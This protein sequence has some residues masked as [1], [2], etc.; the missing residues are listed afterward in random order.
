MTVDTAHTAPHKKN[1]REPYYPLGGNTQEHN[2]K[3][4]KIL[5]GLPMSLGQAQHEQISHQW[6]N[7]VAKM[8]TYTMTEI[9]NRIPNKKW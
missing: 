1:T 9:K 8:I 6:P 4:S 3:V 5:D 7:S 2:G